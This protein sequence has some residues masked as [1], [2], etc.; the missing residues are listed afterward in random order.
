MP[1]MRAPHPESLPPEEAPSATPFLTVRAGEDLVVRVGAVDRQTGVAGIIARC[2]SCENHAL[3][4]SGRWSGG[5]G[6]RG[7]HYYPVAVPIP[8]HSP[9]VLWELYEITLWDG[10]GN[11]R[12]FEAGRDFDPML[13]RVLGRSGVDCTPPRLLGVRLGLV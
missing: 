4:S 10:E 6:P 8:V 9:T 12:L 5:V 13:F 2:R 7:D 3:E 1:A 11:K